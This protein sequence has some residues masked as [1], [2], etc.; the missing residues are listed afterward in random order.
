MQKQVLQTGIDL[1]EDLLRHTDKD[2]QYS[3]AAS[4]QMNQIKLER[5]D[6]YFEL[7]KVLLSGDELQEAAIVYQK[8]LDVCRDVLQNDPQN[9]KARVRIAT[10][11]AMLSKIQFQQEYY[12]KSAESARIAIDEYQEMGD[13]VD[14]QYVNWYLSTTWC[15]LGQAYVRLNHYGPSQEAFD[16]AINFAEKLSQVYDFQLSHSNCYLE[17]SR[18]WR[19]QG[20]LARAINDVQQATK[21]IDD[22]S[23]RSSQS[24]QRYESARV[25]CRH[26]LAEYLDSR[27]DRDG[28][29]NSLDS[30]I[31]IQAGLLEQHPEAEEL[32]LEQIKLLSQRMAWSNVEDQETTQQKIV[33][34]RSR[35]DRISDSPQQLMARIRILNQAMRTEVGR[36][37]NGA[38]MR[39]LHDSLSTL[40]SFPKGFEPEKLGAIEMGIHF[41]M[42]TLGFMEED[43]AQVIK[44][45]ENYRRLEGEPV[46]KLRTEYAIA[47]LHQGP[48][49]KAERVMQEL[50]AVQDG[51]PNLPRFWF[52]QAML[53]G[54]DPPEFHQPEF[55]QYLEMILKHLTQPQTDNLS[56]YLTAVDLCRLIKWLRQRNWDP[57]YIESLVKR[58]QKV[59]FES[60]RVLPQYESHTYETKT[61]L[62]DRRVDPLRELPEFRE[63]VRKINSFER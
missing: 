52:A 45:F 49:G 28:A 25:R 14:Q 17:R 57:D 27:G 15:R 40:K 44:S 7:G 32:I 13:A 56:R 60:I 61:L 38:A 35:F 62:T 29:R 12:Q 50:A 47:L 18:M 8:N 16:Q 39:L 6:L 37:N 3:E 20:S 48:I 19:Q 24:F 34:L 51:R 33:G 55:E 42:A 30:A 63:W 11:R 4:S 26:Q 10:S 21:I 54:R 41:R 58:C 31:E 9:S 53:E 23:I 43:Y 22:V 36:F 2:A 46:F 5:A 1:Y 59:A